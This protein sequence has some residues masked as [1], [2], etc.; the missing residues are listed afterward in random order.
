MKI[1]LRAL[2]VMASLIIPLHA[3]TQQTDV[4]AEMA[5]VCDLPADIENISPDD[6]PLPPEPEPSFCFKLRLLKEYLVLQA[7]LA[8]QHVLDHKEAYLL[9]TLVA[10]GLVAGGTI[11]YAAHKNQPSS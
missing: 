6:I 5:E 10:L 7:E 3:D 9:G 11:A 1:F 8:K 2:M 4:P